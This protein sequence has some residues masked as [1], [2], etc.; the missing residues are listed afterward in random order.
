MGNRT[1]NPS[2]K[3]SP[4]AKHSTSKPSVDRIKSTSLNAT[5]SKEDAISTSIQDTDCNGQPHYKCNACLRIVQILK[6]YDKWNEYHIHDNSPNNNTNTTINKEYDI[7]MFEYISSTYNLTQLN[8]DHIHITE[9]HDDEL[10]DLY[11]YTLKA[12]GIDPNKGCNIKSCK[13]ILRNNRSRSRASTD[14]YYRKSLYNGYEG[15]NEIMTQQTLDK[16]HSYILHSFDSLKLTE[17]EIDI[18]DEQ[19]QKSDNENENNSDNENDSDCDETTPLKDSTLQQ[20][21]KIIDSKRFIMREISTVRQQSFKFAS[22]FHDE[23]MEYKQKDMK[24]DESDDDSEYSVDNKIEKKDEN[25]LDTYS[26]GIRWYYWEYYKN[27]DEVDE[28]NSGKF[29]DFYIAPYHKDFKDEL[30]INPINK[31]SI[32]CWNDVISKG[33][34]LVKTRK[35]R[36]CKANIGPLDGNTHYELTHGIQISLNHI[37][38][39]LLYAN[40]TELQAEYSETYRSNDEEEKIDNI[41]DRRKIW[42]KRHSYY[43]YWSKYLRECV[44]CYGTDLDEDKMNRYK[45]RRGDIHFYHGINCVLYF[46][47]TVA[48]FCNPLSVTPEIAVAQNFSSATGLILQIKGYEDYLRMFNVS[49]LSDYTAESERLFIGGYKRLTIESIINVSTA[50]NYLFYVKAINNLFDL[51]QGFKNEYPFD[52]QIRS[53]FKKLIF[54]QED[55]FKKTYNINEYIVDEDDI[56]NGQEITKEILAKWSLSIPEYI[57]KLFSNWC[58]YTHKL[59]TFNIDRINNF[60]SSGSYKRVKY[61]FINDDNV[62]CRLD[63]LCMLFKNVK[64]V[65]I[66][67][68]LNLH[69]KTFRKLIKFISNESLINITKLKEIIIIKPNENYLTI[70]DAEKQYSNEIQKYGWKLRTGSSK[71]TAQKY[72][73]IKRSKK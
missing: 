29:K 67:N 60:N 26:F 49:W 68:G 73:K 13:I 3:K 52:N 16:I 42:F 25:K 47:K 41:E 5:E 64:F 22:T 35:A 10:E 37:I 72:I 4:K 11:K 2:K 53:I 43:Y 57:K 69:T 20:Y 31:L 30:T 8:D 24:Q 1:S 55:V 66:R 33:E 63:R 48:R 36:M 14:N 38:A 19:Q 70:N 32:N 54:Y 71:V 56:D 62:W 17:K 27:L 44:E 7:G 34:S 58:N 12:I 45:N 59:I 46:K 39:L 50:H 51:I 65:V 28:I 18:I 23:T 6:Y 21:K 61:L 40:F 9:Y 15:S